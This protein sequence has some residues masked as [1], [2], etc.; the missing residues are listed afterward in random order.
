MRARERNERERE[1]D[2]R[3]E[4]DDKITCSTAGGTLDVFV[5]E[6][7]AKIDRHERL[8]RAVFVWSVVRVLCSVE[9]LCEVW[10]V[11][12]CVC[13]ECCVKGC[14]VVLSN[15]CRNV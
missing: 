10:G 6:T 14:E 8:T 15:V 9:V 11:E 12:L 4:R 7:K 5:G 3:G 13:V 1:R 2:E